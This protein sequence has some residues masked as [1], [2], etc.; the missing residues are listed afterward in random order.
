MPHVSPAQDAPV[1]AFKTSA[2]AITV[3]VVVLDRDGKPVEGLAASD[4]TVL[5]DGK[6]QAIAGFEAKRPP[7][8]VMVTAGEAAARVASNEPKESRGRVFTLLIDDLGLSPATALQLK[9]AIENWI[10]EQARDSDE[11]TLVT[12]SGDVWWADLAGR[13]RDDL[14]AV[15]RR[16]T[17]KAP[18]RSAS[19]LSMSDEEAYAIMVAESPIEAA[20]GDACIYAPFGAGAPGPTSLSAAPQSVSVL[21]RVAKRFLANSHCEIVYCPWPP[22][23]QCEGA[24][25]TTAQQFYSAWS[26][27]AQVLLGTLDRLSREMAGT[28]DRKSIL[29]FSE[30]LMRDQD[31]ETRLRRVIDDAQRSNT[32]IYFAKAT[33]LTGSSEMS[34][35]AG[36]PSSPGDLGLINVEQQQLSVAGAQ[37]LALDTGGV[38]VTSNDLAAG[39]ERMA[40]DASSYYLLGYQPDRAPDGHFHKLE[41]KVARK[42]VTVRA[43]RGYVAGPSEAADSRTAGGREPKGAGAAKK[44]GGNDKTAARDL[45]SDLMA[46]I[47]GGSLPVRMTSY[48]QGPDGRGAARVLI[49]LEFDGNKVRVDPTPA[50]GK[51]TLDLAILAVQRDQPKVIPLDQAIELTL[52]KSDVGWWALFREVRLPPGIAQIR[53]VVRDRGT[54]AL[55]SVSQRIAVPDV[56]A[57]YLSTPLITD[58]TLPSKE[59]GDPPLLV[60]SASRRFVA[61]RS[62]FCQYELFSFGGQ[63][64]R[65]VVQVAGGYVLERSSGEVVSQAPPSAIATDGNRVVRRLMFP[66]DRL[67]PGAY[68]LLVTVEDLLGQRTL[69]TKES[70]VIEEKEGPG[71]A[72]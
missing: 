31:M 15:L 29:L 46:G 28:K 14:L 51:A 36:S 30:G 7:S 19:G 65:G 5:E 20:S 47:A 33:G 63:S 56:E 17:A 12:T 55:G 41:V 6:P 68:D 35:E 43:R 11:I 32:S 72:Q 40:T 39:L 8:T 50:G 71:A 53:T 9:P 23:S 60:P 48:L 61:G 24:A 1:P 42:G 69:S 44:K 13:G 45:P 10:R 25:R 70:F 64:L 49:A 59:A 52:R 21:N 27:R 66:A 62:L 34:V 16:V 22:L 54:G 3:D 58:R 4:F 26:R 37:Q 38:A 67:G 2:E 57:P 18:A